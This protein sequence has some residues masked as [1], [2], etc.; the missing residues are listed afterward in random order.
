[1]VASLEALA[2][3]MDVPDAVVVRDQLLDDHTFM[4]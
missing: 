2:A 4:L 1:M 3:L